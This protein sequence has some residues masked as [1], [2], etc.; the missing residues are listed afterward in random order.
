MAKNG[1]EVDLCVHCGGVWLDRGEIFSFT[2]NKRRTAALF[3]AARPA[4][5]ERERRNPRNGALLKAHTLPPVNTA[6]KGRRK[7]KRIRSA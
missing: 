7:A 4:K 6:G 1:V 3:S 5:S 2:K